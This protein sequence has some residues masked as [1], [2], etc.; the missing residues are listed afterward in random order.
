M[1]AF[2][3][4]VCSAL[5]L[6]TPVLGQDSKT[7]KQDPKAPK[8][9]APPKKDTGNQDKLALTK[10]GP[11]KLIPGLC[12]VKYPV[13]TRSPECQAFFDQGLGYYYSYVWIEA[14]RSFETATRFDPD[15]AMAWWGLSKSIEKWGKGQQAEALK[16]AK[17]LLPKASHRE[18][19]LI[20]SRLAEKGMLDNIK[21]ENRKKEAA[22]YLD[23]LLTLYDDDQEGWFA[24]AQLAEGP[25]A[26]VPYYKALLRV[27]PLHPGAHHELVHYYEGIRRPALGWP[28]AIGYMQSSPGIPHAFHMQAHLGTRIGKWDKTT[29]WSSHAIE[30]QQA[31]HKEMNVTPADDWQYSHHLET[32][33]LALIHAGRFKEAHVVKAE[34]ERCKYTQNMP[35]YRMHL[36]EHDWDAALKITGQFKN[37]KVTTAYLRALVY[38]A[39]GEIERAAPEVNVLAE[40]YP[41]K[42]ND[43]ELELRLWETQG[44]LQCAHGAADGGLKLLQ[45]AVDKTKDDY[46][47]H[48]W[49][50]GAYYMESWGVAALK[51]NRLAIAEEAFLESLA[52]DSGS[53]KGALGMQVLCER[54]G[55]TEEAVRFAELAHRSWRKADPGRLEAELHDLRGLYQTGPTKTLEHGASQ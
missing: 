50:G 25:N 4:A 8:Q 3:L 17:E 21:P 6:A 46:R 20:N 36:A 31:Y 12:L 22:K 13:T 2:R 23:E 26:N 24:R 28:H 41:S 47:H 53:I 37:D 38:L 9:D 32:L 55:R 14:A 27:N 30:L 29:D 35:W 10:L 19:L 7:P 39:K 43:R 42:K 1:H 51:A 52:H 11:S 44:I 40:A 15:C 33:M 5:L 16:K 54:Q 18:T 48:A 49:G 34:C 45:K